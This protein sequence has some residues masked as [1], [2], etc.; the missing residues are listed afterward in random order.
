MAAGLAGVVTA[1]I[2]TGDASSL[3][4]TAMEDAATA[5]VNTEVSTLSVVANTIDS[6]ESMPKSLI[7]SETLMNNLP[8]TLIADTDTLEAPSV[9]EA[10]PVAKTEVPTTTTTTPASGV[11]VQKVED[12]AQAA[13][14]EKLALEKKLAEI[15]SDSAKKAAE[16]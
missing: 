5:N 8:Q 4:S 1:S 7:G 10:P 15:R 16:R 9:K 6:V 14:A 11:D 3:P 13:L 12:A 2:G